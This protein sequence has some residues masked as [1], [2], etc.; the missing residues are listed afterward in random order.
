MWVVIA[1]TY[2]TAHVGEEVEVGSRTK[3]RG[4]SGILAKACRSFHPHARKQD[5]AIS[6][7]W[8]AKLVL[9]SFV[10]SF[11]RLA[12]EGNRMEDLIYRGALLWLFMSGTDAPC[13]RTRT[14]MRRVPSCGTSTGIFIGTEGRRETTVVRSRGEASRLFKSHTLRRSVIYKTIFIKNI[15]I[16]VSQLR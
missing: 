12:C 8:R 13:I 2:P 16:L 11:A 10:K 7:S 1:P 9:K 5:L 6:L 4:Y 15:G 14:F 3:F